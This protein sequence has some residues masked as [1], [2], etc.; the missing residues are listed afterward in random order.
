M[1]LCFIGKSPYWILFVPL[2]PAAFAYS[3][4]RCSL[5]P[6][7]R[8][9]SVFVDPATTAKFMIWQQFGYASG[10]FK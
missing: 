7:T 9:D 6:N 4:Q 10:S 1:V 3:V 5:A 8:S 2:C